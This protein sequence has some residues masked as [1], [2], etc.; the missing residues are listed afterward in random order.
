MFVQLCTLLKS[1]EMV[2]LAIMLNLPLPS[3]ILLS[4]LAYENRYL[5]SSD[6]G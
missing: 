2:I 6:G 3:T 4:S 5:T 1:L